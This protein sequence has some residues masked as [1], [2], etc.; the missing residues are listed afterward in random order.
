MESD[1]EALGGRLAKVMAG[2][3]RLTTPPEVKIQRVRASEYLSGS[4]SSAGAA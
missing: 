1:I 4:F 3:Q 2:I